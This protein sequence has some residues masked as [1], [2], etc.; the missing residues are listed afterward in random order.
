MKIGQ[1]FTEVNKS[2]RMESSWRRRGTEQ[3]E[4]STLE[5]N[6]EARC[7]YH[8]KINKVLKARYK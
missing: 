3:G 8:L 7:I 6:H 4:Q 2:R 1:T 5:Y